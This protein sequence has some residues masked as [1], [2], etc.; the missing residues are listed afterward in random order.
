L[1]TPFVADL[2]RPFVIINFLG[3]MRSQ[4]VE[5]LKDFKASITIL[6]T[7][8]SWVFVFAISGFYLF[9]YS[10]E[11]AAYFTTVKRSFMSMFTLLTTANFPDVMLLAYNENYFYMLFFATYLLVGLYFLLNLLLASVF[12]KYKKRLTERIERNANL[13]RDQVLKAYRMFDVEDRG[14]LTSVEFRRFAVFIF[15]LKLKNRA[16]LEQLRRILGKLDL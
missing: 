5:S 8:F 12:S 16:G 7:I 9:R 4:L 15:D 2:L 6:M 10:L 14:F 3:S 11:G 13:R 1:S